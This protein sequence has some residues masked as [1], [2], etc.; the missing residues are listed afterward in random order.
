MNNPVILCT[1]KGP[2]AVENVR[3]RNGTLYDTEFFDWFFESDDYKEMLENNSFYIG[4]DHPEED[5]RST[6]TF[7]LEETAG[8]A[9]PLKRLPNGEVEITIDILDTPK[10]RI[11]ATL[12]MYGSYLGLSTRAEG[13]TE[14]GGR[15]IPGE[16]EFYGSDFVS[17]PSQKAS[18]MRLVLNESRRFKCT[19]Q[20]IENTNNYL[21]HKGLDPINE[22]KGGIMRNVKRLNESLKGRKLQILTEGEQGEEVLVARDLSTGEDKLVMKVDVE[23]NGENGILLEDGTFVPYDKVD[24]P[25]LEKC[26][27]GKRGMRNIRRNEGFLKSKLGKKLKEGAEDEVKKEEIVDPAEQVLADTEE[28]IQERLAEGDTEDVQDQLN[29]TA[30]ILAQNLEDSM[31]EAGVDGEVV[32]DKVNNI[33]VEGKSKIVAIRGKVLE[34]YDRRKAKYLESFNMEKGDKIVECLG[35]ILGKGSRRTEGRKSGKRGPVRG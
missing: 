31:E 16:Y 33:I 1:V 23:E 30:E 27:E 22:S 35:R 3:T 11:A 2:M 20:D 4:L 34:V 9:H 10:G 7:L 13:N 5:I 14:N 17:V 32:L 28:S 18:R 19:D 21:I 15:V 12:A 24:E 26:K 29:E 8:I 25:S 6:L